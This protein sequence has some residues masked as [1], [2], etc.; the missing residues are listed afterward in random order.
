M[1]ETLPKQ[2]VRWFI[3]LVPLYLLFFLFL[4]QPVDRWARAAFSDTGVKSFGSFLSL[5]A[6]G[7]YVTLALTLG[8]V[9]GIAGV[10]ANQGKGRPWTAAVFYVC[11]SCAIGIVIGEGLKYLLARARPVELFDHGT[12][13]FFFFSDEYN[14]NSTPSGHT[15]RIFSLMTALSVLFPRGRLLFLGL[16]AL[17]GASRVV[18]TAH[19][20]SDVLF[21]AFIGVFAALWACRL[22]GG[23]G[24]GVEGCQAEGQEMFPSGSASE[25][26]SGSAPPPGPQRTALRKQTTDEH[27]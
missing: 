12:Y 25:S 17:V 20:P 3:A 2:T 10:I 19:Y 9:A 1:M 14:L 26:Q 18:V 5:L 23:A 21:G 7:P 22:K 6:S 15:I 11:V 8:F 24:E 16:A 13:G 27:G 4:D